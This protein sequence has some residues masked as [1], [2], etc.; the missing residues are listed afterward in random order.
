MPGCFIL[1]QIAG[2]NIDEEQFDK[3]RQAKILDLQLKSALK[4]KDRLSSG[5]DIEKSDIF[6][7]L[8]EKFINKILDQYNSSK[9]W[10][11][12]STS[13]VINSVDLKIF[14]GSAVATVNM[15]AYNNIHNVDVDLNLD[16]LL[17]IEQSKKDLQLKLEPFNIAP[18]VTTRG[19]YSAAEDVIKN[20]VKINLGELGNSLP[21]LNIPVILD[22]KILLPGSKTDIKDKINFT[23]ENP[24]RHISFKMKIKELLFIEGKALIALIIEKSEVQ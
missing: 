21:G 15:T 16:C 8:E 19:I 20:L 5:E 9:G 2:S 11:D 10:L 7:V 13:Y 14:C 1:H 17:T 18:K 3:A 4:L 24:K 22:E 6:L 23:I 12:K